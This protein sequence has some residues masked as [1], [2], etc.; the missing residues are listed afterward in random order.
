MYKF[1]VD[2]RWSTIDQAP[3]E[4]DWRGNINNIYN[5]PT[6]PQE[7]D[8]PRYEPPVA[9]K[10]KIAS[11]PTPVP[12]E[13]K[14]KAPTPTPTPASK[15]A[16][17][18]SVEVPAKSKEPVKDLTPVVGK[19]KTL[20]VDRKDQT[21]AVD[22]KDQ[23]PIVNKDPTPIVGKED[24]TPIVRKKDQIPTVGKKDQTPTVDKK[25]QTPTVNKEPSPPIDVKVIPSVPEVAPTPVAPIK[26][27]KPVDTPPAKVYLP[28]SAD[29]ELTN[30]L[31]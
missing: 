1:I 24:Q 16:G 18:G 25:D 9:Q 11:V 13:E 7:V 8:T 21:P 30:T 28:L 27:T 23:T 14:K 29:T 31:I 17:R 5:A 22:K 2:G 19:D 3:T 15:P 26:D 6:K 12:V 10:P 4:A 20:T